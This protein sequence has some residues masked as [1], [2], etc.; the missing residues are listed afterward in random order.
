MKQ[1]Q[2]GAKRRLAAGDTAQL[3]SHLQGAMGGHR[4]ILAD[5]VSAAAISMEGYG[6]SFAPDVETAISTF[7]QHAHAAFTALQGTG[8]AAKQTLAPAMEDAAVY[9]G[10]ASQAP[11]AWLGQ[12]R[13]SESALAPHAEQS[14]SVLTRV[15]GHSGIAGAQDERSIAVEAYDERNN[16]D[17]TAYSIAY[18]LQASKQ[19]EFGETFYPT[20]VVAPDQVGYNVQIRL[21]YAYNEVSRAATGALNDFGRKNLIRAIIDATILAVDQTKIIPVFR[22]S[23]GIDSSANFV[24]G[25]TP[26]TLTVD[27]AALTTAPLKIGAKFSLLGISQTTAALAAGLEDQTDAVDSSV[28]LAKVYLHLNDGTHDEFIPVD[29]SIL[30]SSDFNTSI[31]GN[32]RKLQLN[33]STQSVLLKSGMLTAAGAASLVLAALSTNTVRV[34]FDV[35][36]YV[37]QDTGD[38]TL[39]ATNVVIASAK[40]ANGVDLG[41]ATLTTVQGLFAGA[42]VAGYDLL[43]YRTNSNR[44]NRGKLLDIQ[45]VNYLYTVPLL[46]PITVLRPVTASDAMDGNLVADLVTATRT[47]TANAAVTALLATASALAGSAGSNVESIANAPQLF[48]ASSMLVTP[49]Y[50]TATID[51]AANIDSQKSSE[52]IADLQALL[53]NKI[54]D[55]ATQLAVQSGYLAAAEAMFEGQ[56]PKPVVLIGTDP[57]IA[58]YL[59]LQGDTRLLGDMFDFKIVSTLDSRMT[60]KLF[61]ALGQG[62]AFNSGVPNPLHFGAMAW[63]PELTLMMPMVRNGAQSMELTVQPSYRHVTNLPVLGQIIVSNID[64]VVGSKVALNMHSV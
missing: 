27:N 46:P 11:K 33:F 6:Q 2:Y 57:Y 60:G 5:N 31:Q 17:V 19:G 58:R 35:N 7:T 54:R 64:Q 15:V 49:T 25:I 9:A 62:S 14:T 23:G 20:V 3:L 26:V 22:N 47:Q 51:C 59:Q 48:G 18:N 21:L 45:H 53:M 38:C 28:R 61:V 24:S 12:K 40:D 30:P 39:S 37:V 55:Q 50:L 63:R 42:T 29:T 52:R 32:T 43:A 8:K 56:A 41:G 4:A 44:R 13:A 1:S 34:A 16:K 10:L 36:G